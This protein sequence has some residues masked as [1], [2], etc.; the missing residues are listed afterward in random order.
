MAIYKTLAEI[1]ERDDRY[2]VNKITYF[3]HTDDET[4]IIP[5]LNL[6]DKYRRFI[7]PYVVQYTMTRKERN[8]Y[9]F[10]PYQLAYDVYGTPDLG[11]MVMILNDKECAS[12]F[13][14]RRKVSLI[15][16]NRLGELYEMITMKSSEKLEENWSE[17]LKDMER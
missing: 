10:R 8:F 4:L 14:L 13:V 5:D 9:N 12:K 15:P 17:Q 2:D 1:L 7:A 16:P 6:I 11:L 3:T